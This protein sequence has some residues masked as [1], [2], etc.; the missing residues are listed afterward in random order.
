VREG[1]S[2][3]NCLH[4]GRCVSRAYI[5]CMSIR[6]R[7]YPDPSTIPMLAKHC[8]D[9]RTVWNLGLEQRKLWQPGRAQKINT[10]TQMRELAEARRAFD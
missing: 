10:A 5:C 1:S 6:Q 2:D 7:L 4:P 8:Q 3:L 9:A